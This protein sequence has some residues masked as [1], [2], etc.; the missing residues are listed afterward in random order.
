VVDPLKVAD[1]L[2]VA[3]GVRSGNFL[4]CGSD[5]PRQ[6][7]VVSDTLTTM[8]LCMSSS[9]SKTIARA[10]AAVVRA[11]E[12]RATVW[13]ANIPSRVNQQLEPIVAGA[14]TADTPTA[15]ASRR[16]DRL[17]RLIHEYARA[18]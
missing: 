2:A 14:A 18:A 10:A 8:A 9:V 13:D 12:C 7:H 16:I 5:V 17:G 1:Y 15:V 3:R 11:T 4:L 6:S